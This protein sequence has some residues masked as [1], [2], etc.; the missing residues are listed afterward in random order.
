MKTGALVLPEITFGMIEAST[1]RRP[2]SPRTRSRSSTTAIESGEGD[3]AELTRLAV[4]AIDKAATKGVIHKNQAARRKSRL[5]A[6]AARA[7][8]AS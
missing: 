6:R 2:S 1:T 5:A 4:K 8:S 3:V 7:S